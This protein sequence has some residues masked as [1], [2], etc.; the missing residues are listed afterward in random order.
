M[1]DPSFRAPRPGEKRFDR[2]AVAYDDAGLVFIGRIRS[3]WVSRAGCPKN[4]RAALEA[5]QPAAV[6]V[7]APWREALPGLEA[8][9]W[10]FCLTWLDRAQ[11]DLALQVP[12]HA[13][14]PRGTFT[15][16]SPVRPNPIGLHLARI[17]GIDQTSGRLEIDAIDVLDGTPLLD[18]K[19]YFATVDSPSPEPAG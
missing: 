14:G 19:P 12:R 16:R 9:A 3:S 8:G 7:D 6:E 10:I 2:E 4:R 11:R 5:G 13:D 17:V 18:I 15:L 1:S